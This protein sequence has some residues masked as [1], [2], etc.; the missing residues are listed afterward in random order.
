MTSIC[1][2]NADLS[3]GAG[4]T[5]YG[6]LMPYGQVAEVSDGFGAY[7]ERFEFGAFSRSISQRSGKV[8]LFDSHNRAKLPLGRAVELTEQSD[9]LHG[10]FLL[11]NTRDADDAL[12]LIRSG[13]VDFSVGFR[14]IR[15][16]RDGAVTVRLECAL[17]ETSLTG[18]PAYEGAQVQGVRSGR[19]VISR[20]V[21]QARLDLLDW[22]K[23]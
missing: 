11:A 3:A 21:A 12:E 6:I 9:G 8:R 17:L 13:A 22:N 19:P 4:R 5:V 10:S 16:R 20:A 2:R 18:C 7:R 15:E 23:R 1:Y 14:P